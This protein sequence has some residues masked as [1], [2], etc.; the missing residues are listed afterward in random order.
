MSQILIIANQNADPIRIGFGGR[1]V[2]RLKVP[3]AISEQN[4]LHAATQNE[5]QS[6]QQQVEPL[7]PGQATDNSEQK[8]IGCGAAV[9]MLTRS[10]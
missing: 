5:W 7:L 9:E 8:C 10:T 1:A 4:Q 3:I 6:L 2:A